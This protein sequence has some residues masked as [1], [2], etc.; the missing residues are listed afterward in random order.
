MGHTRLTTWKH[1]HTRRR[2]HTQ[3]RWGMRGLAM[4]QRPRCFAFCVTTIVMAAGSVV[5]FW[6]R[7]GQH[8]NILMRYWPCCP[9][10][11]DEPGTVRGHG[12]CFMLRNH[13]VWV[14]TCLF[15]I[16]KD[17]TPYLHSGGSHSLNT[18]PLLLK[19]ILLWIA[20]HLKGQNQVSLNVSSSVKSNQ[21]L[22][23]QDFQHEWDN[24]ILLAAL[25]L[26]HGY[27]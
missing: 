19:N 7:F 3:S 21:K 23:Q 13:Y 16:F 18:L 26:L 11:H 25:L 12:L 4:Q 22:Q 24:L 2:V 1:T 5:T 10:N 9:L 14:V 17:Q 27:Y 8:R 15:P 6:I 20:I